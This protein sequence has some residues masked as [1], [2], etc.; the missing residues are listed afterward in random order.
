MIA[1]IVRDLGATSAGGA[2][3]RNRALA[4]AVTTSLPGAIVAEISALKESVGCTSQCGACGQITLAAYGHTSSDP[5]HWNYCHRARSLLTE[6]LRRHG[7]TSVLVSDLQL[8]QYFH[9]AQQAGLCTA[10]DM[11]N[12]ESE[13]YAQN[14]AHPLSATLNPVASTDISAIRAVEQHVSRMANLITFATDRDERRFKRCHTPIATSVIPNAVEVCEVSN[15][16][17]APQGPVQPDLL[18]LGYLSYFP[19]TEAA[20][21]LS[22]EIY[23]RVKENIPQAT[24]L[25]AGRR[26]PAQLL[27]RGS[28]PGIRILPDPLDTHPLLRDRILV[29]PLNLGGG[30]RL[31]ILEAFAA[32]TPVISTAKGVEGL[33][34]L[35]GVHY[36]QVTREP[37]SYIRRIKELMSD[38]AADVRRRAKAF[39]LVQ[40]KYSWTSLRVHVNRAIELLMCSRP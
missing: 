1:L 3:L 27:R 39:N 33:A 11:H 29:V 40:E 19:N 26:P 22:D 9:A 5:F 24:L 4:A 38:P 8:H 30:S 28:I 23:P 13:L 14:V 15:A 7:V 34:A 35:P 10:L 21:W 20:L 6:L 25:I 17:P 32:G 12:F 36:L 37:A 18:Y 31:K 2:I 16:L